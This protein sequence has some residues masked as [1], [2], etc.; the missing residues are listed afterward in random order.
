MEYYEQTASDCEKQLKTSIKDGLSDKEAQR[1]LQ[2]YGKNILEDKKRTPVLVRFFEQFDDFM[3]IILLSAAAISFVTSMLWGNKDITEPI[4]ILAIVTLNAALGTIQEMRAEHSIEALKKMSSPTA[5]VIRNGHEVRINSELVVPGDIVRLKSGDM[6]CADCRLVHA[7]SL[8]V[9]ESALTGETHEVEKIADFICPTLTAIG[10]IKNGVMA[11]C[12]V[13]GGTALAIAVKTGMDTEIGKIASMLINAERP[14]TPLQKRLAKTGRTLGIAALFICGI[15]FII[16]TF[17][18]IPPLDMFMTSVSLAVAAIP[19]GLPA[20]VTILLALGVM[21]MSKHNAIVRHLPSVETLGSATVICTD[22]TGTLTQNKMKASK[23]RSNDTM[24]LFRL[25]TLCS[26]NGEY[27]NPT[28]RALLTAAQTHGISIEAYKKSHPCT[29]QIPFDSERKRM[30]VISDGKVIVKG[31]IECILPLC[32]HFTSKSGTVTMTGDIKRKILKNNAEMASNA[33]RVIAV[34]YRNDS[35]SRQIHETDLTFVGLIGIYD[36]PRPEVK[37]AVAEAKN[38]GIRTLMIT[39]DHASTA[40]AIARLTGIASGSDTVITGTD[41]DRADDNELTELLKT[42][43]VFARVTPQH[44]L[45]IVTLLKKSGEIIA[46][47]GDGVNDAPALKGADIGC[48][49]GINGTDVAKSASDIILTDDNFATIVYAVKEGRAIYDNIKKSVKFLLS[50]NIGE[51]LTVLFSIIFNVAAPLTAIE[52]LWVNLV[53]DSLPAI[54]LGLDPPDK[55]IMKRP[56]TDP[57]KGLFTA[58][59]WRSITFEGLMIGA[60]SLFA[61]TLG[62]TLTSTAAVARTMSF[63]VLS[64]SQLTHAFNMRSSDSV[65]GVGFFSNKPLVLSFIAGITAQLGLI[66]ISPV[67]AVFDVVPLN[68]FCLTVSVILSFMPLAIVELQKKLNSVL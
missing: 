68:A 63:F 20:I 50:S 10:D 11:S 29:A 18:K 52:L 58:G 48:S 37:Q 41:I 55:D 15:I 53:T 21:R 25:C 13:T 27:I 32:T 46:M 28:D 65:L 14:E 9:D 4:I 3:I 24:L 57:K 6:V 35:A 5:T 8:R 39:G 36:P 45:R 64:V 67:S 16:G 12:C 61:Y 44:K 60:L 26:E 66:Y 42:H 62:M 49:M 33:L 19:E 34:A 38:A 31:A 23:I 59:L 22:K 1:R 54:A 30:S 56:P 2:K 40:L 43:S 47:T 51:I 17:K 7:D